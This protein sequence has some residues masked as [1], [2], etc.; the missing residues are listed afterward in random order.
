MVRNVSLSYP[1]TRRT[2]KVD[3]YFGRKVKDSYDWME[4]FNSEEVKVWVNEQNKVTNDFLDDISFRQKIKD[5]LVDL[6]NYPKYS[7]PFKKGAWYYFFKNDGLQNQSVLWRCKDLDAGAEVFIDP[8][9]FS[10]EGTTSLSSLS[11]S[12]DGKYVAYGVSK[13][14]SQWSDIFIIDT[15]T[16]EILRDKVENILFDGS[17]GYTKVVWQKDGFFYAKFKEDKNN[18]FSK[19]FCRVYYHKIGSE[20]DEMVYEDKKNPSIVYGIDITDDESF[21]SIY[22]SFGNHHNSLFVKDLRDENSDWKEIISGYEFET[23]VLCERDNFLYLHTN[24]G[25]SIFRV[26]RVNLDRSEFENWEDLIPESEHLL[27]DVYFV[28]DK[29]VAVYLENVSS[30]LKVFDFEGSFENEIELPA[31]GSVYGLKFDKSKKDL[32]FSFTSFVYASESLVY[33]FETKKTRVFRKSEVKFDCEGYET[34]QVWYESKD[35]TKIPMF[36]VFK[37]GL[38]LDGNNPTL[39]YGYGGFNVSV[40]PHFSLANLILLEQGFVYAVPNLRGGGE[41]GEEWHK[42]GMK[43]SKQ[44]VFDDFICAGEYLIEQGYTCKEK[45]AI[46]GGSNGGLLV[47]ACIVQRPDLFEVAIPI[48]GVLDML[49]YQYF[50]CGMDWVKDYGVSSDE[51]DFKYLVK[52]SPYHNVNED[53]YPK[54][55]IMTSNNDD[56]VVPMHSYKFTA[57]LQEMQQSDNPVLLRIETDSG[58]QGGSSTSKKIDEIADRLSFLFWGLDVKFD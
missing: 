10:K 47:G 50:G 43:G 19:E 56:N 37:Q 31:I 41:F 25:A 26:V 29:F 21:L 15:E 36:L 6:W 35:G 45:L 7:L 30:K 5:R 8:N 12:K 4:N 14:G 28:Q 57:V 34:K 55:F 11:F 9:D 39:L 17:V 23:E 40:T 16:K 22:P 32:Y 54:T 58:H 24:K 44:N 53:Y 18:L 13:A 27:E 46:M 2:D 52:Y 20:V 1:K 49:R 42:Q 48:V 51:D 38:N 33:N 3:I